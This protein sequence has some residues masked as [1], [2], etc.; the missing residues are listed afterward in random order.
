MEGLTRELIGMRIAKELKDG[1][2]INLGSGLPNYVANFIPEGI[3]VMIHVENGLLG[4]GPTPPKDDWDPALINASANPITLL[5]GGSFFHSGDAFAMIR[6]G[7]LDMTVLGAFQ[8]SEKG[9]LAN[10]M[11]QGETLGSPG[12]GMDLACGSKR[13]VIA[14]EHTTV[15][16]KPK[17]VKECTYPLTRRR[18]V[19]TIFTNL[20]VIEVTQRGLVLKELAPRVTREQV[21]SVTEPTLII[22]DSFKEMAL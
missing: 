11:L 4:A 3:E 15:D 14:M 17:I 20:A 16:G 22:D 5:P 9:D 6:G 12:G 21:Q 2:C 1:M 19:N 13:V 8:V 18:A 10:W 7:H